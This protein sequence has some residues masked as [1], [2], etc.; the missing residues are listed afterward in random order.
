MCRSEN[1][2]CLYPGPKCDTRT[3]PHPPVLAAPPAE[4]LPV[5]EILGLQEEEESGSVKRGE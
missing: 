1:H 2:L 5:S 4:R 3:S